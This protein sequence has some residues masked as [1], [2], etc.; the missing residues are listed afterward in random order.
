MKNKMVNI[1]MIISM[2]ICVVLIYIPGMTIAFGTR[3]FPG[4]YWVVPIP[5]GCCILAWAEFR[6]WVG[7]EKPN[8]LAAKIL[9]W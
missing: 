9:L 7:R 5:F 2:F 1:A 6:K 3:P 8:S 4:L